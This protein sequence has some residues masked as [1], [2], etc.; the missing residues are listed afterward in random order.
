VNGRLFDIAGQRF[1]SLLVLE[2]AGSDRFKN[3]LWLTRCDCGVESIKIGVLLVSSRTRSCGC[4]RRSNGNWTHGE[5]RTALYRIYR[6]MITRCEYESAMGFPNYGGRGIKVCDAWRQ[7]FSAFKSDIGPRPSGAFSIDRID[8]DRGY[9]PGNVRW[10]TK[11]EQ[12]RNTSRNHMLTFRGVTKCIAAWA[13]EL[14]LHRATVRRR[15]VSYGWTTERAL[16]TPP[17]PQGR[18]HHA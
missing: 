5:S 8:N 7:S 18:K 4:R 11:K 13:E 10:A 6:S 12:Q 16:T 2:R 1:G 14:G 15:L 3:A 17:G 9:E